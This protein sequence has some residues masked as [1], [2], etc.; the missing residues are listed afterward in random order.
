MNFRLGRQKT[1]CYSGADADLACARGAKRTNN[2]L[3]RHLLEVKTADAATEDDA[4]AVHFHLQ[5]LYP[6]QGSLH[7]LGLMACA[8]SAGCCQAFCC[9]SMPMSLELSQERS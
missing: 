1:H 6:P 7:D 9:S 8:S 3:E 5:R 4:F 2:R